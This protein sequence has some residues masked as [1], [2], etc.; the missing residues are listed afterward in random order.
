MASGFN[1][2][3]QSGENFR[4]KAEA[5]SINRQ[6]RISTDRRFTVDEA[7]DVVL[8]LR[9]LSEQARRG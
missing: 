1:R 8:R 9:G 4:L 6:P 3:I 7:T 2:K 5:T